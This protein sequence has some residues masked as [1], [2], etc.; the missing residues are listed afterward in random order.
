MRAMF[1]NATAF[2]QDVGSWNTSSVTN[3]GS[4]VLWRD[5]V[6]QNVGTWDTSVML[7][8]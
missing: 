3:M 6:N 8:T 4:Y 2:N 1:V 5:F 7:P